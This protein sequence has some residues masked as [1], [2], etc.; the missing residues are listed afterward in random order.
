M[1]FCADW[2]STVLTSLLVRLQKKL[3]SDQVLAGI[4]AAGLTH[5]IGQDLAEA[6][7]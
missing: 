7:W 1:A 6:L 2:M 4:A 3:D 5:D